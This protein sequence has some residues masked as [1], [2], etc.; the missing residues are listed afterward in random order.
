MDLVYP[1]HASVLTRLNSCDRFPIESS[2]IHLH[3]QDEKQKLED[4]ITDGIPQV[5]QGLV[6]PP[7]RMIFNVF[8]EEKGKYFLLPCRMS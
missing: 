1:H 2:N 6:F 4:I 5:L 8:F 7:C 3:F